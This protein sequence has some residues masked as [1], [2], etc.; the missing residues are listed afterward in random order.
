MSTLDPTREAFELQRC[1]GAEEA[2]AGISFK[3]RGGEIF[4]LL[5]PKNAGKNTTILPL[6]SQI[7]S[8]SG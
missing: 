8:N 6:T 5:G 2:M 4:G 3:V 7:D 1:F